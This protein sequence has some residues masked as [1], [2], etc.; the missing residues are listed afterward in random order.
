MF[1]ILRCGGYMVDLWNV[2]NVNVNECAVME[3][4]T[5]GSWLSASDIP[6]QVAELKAHIMAGVKS[7]FCNDAVHR[8]HI[9]NIRSSAV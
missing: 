8:D 5:V 7:I 9:L 3:Y 1:H 4:I 2:C 6:W